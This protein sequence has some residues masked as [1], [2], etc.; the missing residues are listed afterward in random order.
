MPV[1]AER[2][3]VGIVGA[4]PAGLLLSHLLALAGIESVVVEA[5]SRAH[6]A[7]RQRAGLLEDG[8]VALLRAAGLAARLDREGLPHGGIYPQFAGER[9]HIDFRDL[10]GRSVTI[11]AQT[12]IVKDLI[13]ERTRAGAALHFDVTGTEV[14]GLGTGRPLLRYTD[15]AG[16]RHEVTCEVIAGCDGFHGICRPA[17]PDGLLTV[18]ERAY[19]YAWPTSPCWPTRSSRWSATATRARPARTRPPA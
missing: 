12:E 19:P 5:R 7:A 18:A 10:A 17:M 9:H 3:Q 6:C 1:A 16:G 11:Y 2:S 13:A 15:A 8:T 14:T 4:G